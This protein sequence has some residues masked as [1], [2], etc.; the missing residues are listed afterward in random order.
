MFTV[1]RRAK[2][3]EKKKF[4]FNILDVIIILV[5]VACVVGAAIRY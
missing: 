3:S 2:M 1:R 5:V 4:R